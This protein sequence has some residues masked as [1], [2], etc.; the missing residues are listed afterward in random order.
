MEE[1]TD[2]I[3][4]NQ[5]KPNNQKRVLIITGILILVIVIP[6]I[7]L[8][9]KNNYSRKSTESTKTGSNTAKQNTI[10]YLYFESP[11]IKLDKS[12]LKN[13]SQQIVL[14]T[15]GKEI[16]VVQVEI[17]FDPKIVSNLKISK[18]PGILTTLN[19]LKEVQSVVDKKTG[20]A[21]IALGV[22]NNT[23]GIIGK[24]KLIN[25]TF[26][27]SSTT[28][29]KSVITITDLTQLSDKGKVIPFEK[30]DLELMFTSPT[31]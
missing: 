25:V 22:E 6:L 12:S 14:D 27:V 5:T 23:N 28:L 24:D 4:N 30:S 8:M 15:Q 16:S 20:K 9:L 21:F 2:Q 29:E 1:N 13:L 31:Q 10:A 19:T 3:I 18:N 11:S 26:D 7:F 17:S